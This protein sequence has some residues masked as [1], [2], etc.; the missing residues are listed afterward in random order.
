MGKYVMTAVVALASCKSMAPKSEVK[1]VGVVDAEVPAFAITGG[2]TKNTAD[3]NTVAIYV[4]NGNQ[5]LGVGSGFF[6]AD[7]CVLTAA[8]NFVGAPNGGGGS[9]I[10][11]QTPGAGVNVLDPNAKAPREVVLRVNA[12][13][14]EADPKDLAVAW[15]DYRVQDDPNNPRITNYDSQTPVYDVPNVPVKHKISGFGGGANGS[16][17]QKAGTSNATLTGRPT[18]RAIPNV[19]LNNT[20]SGLLFDISA[21]NNAGSEAGDSGGPIFDPKGPLAVIEGRLNDP[22]TNAP[23]GGS[24]L[25]FAPYQPWI[26]L[27]LAK[28]CKPQG[29]AGAMRTG[30]T[31][32]P[33][34]VVL[35]ISGG[36]FYM[37]ASPGDPAETEVSSITCAGVTSSVCGSSFRADDPFMANVTITAKV[38]PPPGYLVEWARGA[39]KGAPTGA[40]YDNST[41][42][43]TYNPMNESSYRKAG[44]EGIGYRILP[45]GSSSGYGSTSGGSGYGSTSGGSG[46]TN[47]S[48]SGYGTTSG[49]TGH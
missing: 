1:S 38:T 9:A 20:M 28:F 2:D 3:K 39:C 25:L 12:L 17:I 26:R 49:G 47:G 42:T 14:N 36:A 21:K 4:V 8:H 22:I 35:G 15:I 43:W 10:V 33:V 40:P 29:G 13:P 5:A 41:C 19:Q 24:A 7:R 31:T 11:F 16:A 48:S 30:D 34:Q 32:L 45:N 18:Q 44:Y 23:V 27:Q 37:N 6:A 46:A